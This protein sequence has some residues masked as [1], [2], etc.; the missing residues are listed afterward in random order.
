MPVKAARKADVYLPAFC[1]IA[2]TFIHSFDYQFLMIPLAMLFEE[3]VKA[4][5]QYLNVNHK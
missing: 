4:L 3:Y 1:C 5:Q 2:T